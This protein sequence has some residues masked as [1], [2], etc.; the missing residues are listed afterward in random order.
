[1][2]KKA[3]SCPCTIPAMTLDVSMRFAGAVGV[4][5]QHRRVHLAK[6]AATEV[7]TT[8]EL[9]FVTGKPSSE[10]SLL[11]YS[12]TDSQLLVAA[13]CTHWRPS[14]SQQ[15]SLSSVCITITVTT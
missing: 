2:H 14:P 10:V 1:M 3:V 11:S 12:L 6:A 8:K 4:L 9:S 5:Q 15:Q 7:V 13:H